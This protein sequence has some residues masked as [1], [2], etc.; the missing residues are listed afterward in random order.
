MS[1]AI[2]LNQYSQNNG[3]DG[4]PWD[5]P[6]F[7]WYGKGVINEKTFDTAGLSASMP[8]GTEELQSIINISGKG[9]LYYTTFDFTANGSYLLKISLDDEILLFIGYYMSDWGGFSTNYQGYT[10]MLNTIKSGSSTSGSISNLFVNQYNLKQGLGLPY[11]QF[12]LASSHDACNYA[13][14]LPISFNKNLKVEFNTSIV[15]CKISYMYDL[16][17]E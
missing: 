14:L 17:D 8:T 12:Q 9:V 11:K 13:T 1:E 7:N 2:L 4:N 5:I 3:G 15:N 16:F 6:P 10:S